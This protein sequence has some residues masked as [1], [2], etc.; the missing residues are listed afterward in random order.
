MAF[1]TKDG[2]LVVGAGN[3][4]QFGTVC[5][6]LNLPEVSK[7]SRYKTNTLRVQNRKELIDKLSTRFAEKTT[8][9]WLQLFEGSEVPYGPINNI[10]QVF[11]DPQHAMWVLSFSKADILWFAFQRHSV[12]QHKDVVFEVNMS[13][14]EL[15]PVQLLQKT[16]QLQLG[17]SRI[18]PKLAIPVWQFYGIHGDQAK[19]DGI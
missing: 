19:G 14:E 15:L 18:S 16:S 12:K 17:F 2:Y 10:Q 13:V 7:D 4:H 11:S 9:E 6:I 5:K 1:K 8:L 3:D